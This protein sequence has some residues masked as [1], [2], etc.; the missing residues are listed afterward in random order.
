MYASELVE[1]SNTMLCMLSLTDIANYCRDR[2][3]FA[4]MGIL[5][6]LNETEPK[7]TE[8]CMSATS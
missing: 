7:V 1:R 5:E 4:T 3:T 2:H 6:V 8:S